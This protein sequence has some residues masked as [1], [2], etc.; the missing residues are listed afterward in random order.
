MKKSIILFG[1]LLF[2]TTQSCDVLDKE[3]LDSIST[4]Q[5]F[6]NANAQALEQYCNDLYPKLI[7]GHGNPNEYNFGM[8]ETDFQSDDLLPW[9]ANSVAFSQHSISTADND[10]WKW[11]N[12]RACNAFMQDYE[13]SFFIFCSRI[14]KKVSCISPFVFSSCFSVLVKQFVNMFSDYFFSMICFYPKG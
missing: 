8:M 10:N 9:D 6:A 3:P 13:L 7:T 4:Q 2:L 12:I 1:G 14:E 5:Y 11:E